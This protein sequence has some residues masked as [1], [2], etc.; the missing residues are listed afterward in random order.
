MSDVDKAKEPQPRTDHDYALSWIRREGRGRVFY[1]AH[2]HHERV[3][4]MTPMLEHLLAG[5]QYALGDLRADD[6][7][8]IRAADAR[9]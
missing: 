2:G 6:A 7:P 1:E 9:R 3:Y 8:S 5:A 4:A